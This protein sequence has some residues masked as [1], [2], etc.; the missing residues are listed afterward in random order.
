MKNNIMIVC[1]LVLFGMISACTSV[2]ETVPEPDFNPDALIA[3]GEKNISVW[4]LI[5]E[6]VP[7]ETSDKEESRVTLQYLQEKAL[8][9]PAIAMYNITADSLFYAPYFQI[10]TVIVGGT[11]GVP[12]AQPI[13]FNQK[14]TM[15]LTTIQ[16]GVRIKHMENIVDFEYVFPYT[17]FEYQVKITLKNI[18]MRGTTQ[19]YMISE[20][21]DKDN[22][23]GVRRK[24][25]AEFDIDLTGGNML[26][27]ETNIEISKG[28]VLFEPQTIALFVKSLNVKLEK[29]VGYFPVP[30]LQLDSNNL[31]MN[32]D[33]LSDL[34]N[35]FDMS[36][37]K[38]YLI[39]RNKGFG[40][41]ACVDDL[42]L[43]AK[44]AALTK[45]VSLSSNEEMIFEA[46]LKNTLRIDTFVFTPE[47]SNL[48]D[49]LNLP[50]HGNINYNGTI[51]FNPEG[52]AGTDNIIYADGVSQVD[53]YIEIPLVMKG[54]SLVFQDTLKNLICDQKVLQVAQLTVYSKTDI[55]FG[56]TL[57][58][59]TFYDEGN[60]LLG[61]V[62]FN[63]ALT[64]DKALS[65]AVGPEL[66]EK[67]GKAKYAVSVLCI[68]PSLDVLS[69]RQDA[70]LNINYSLL[71]ETAN[72]TGK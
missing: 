7:E 70:A 71:G 41:P 1:T 43:K 31:K 63:E 20:R 10:D 68:Y 58:K 19:P 22:Q 25:S 49:F 55:P 13:T 16:P 61:E 17:G 9:L 69:I 72:N 62:E 3:L 38:Y 5:G 32:L 28:A 26:K 21:V 51:R 48:I 2:K 12:L 23:K 45:S 46:N 59:I 53:S 40:L 8:T 67:V 24:V 6:S 11:F 15:L 56:M 27:M 35:A 14:D 37:P 52:N 36:D 50:P 4:D 30:P 57:R 65:L 29:A 18:F 42:S 54:T 47:N 33:V 39:I 34:S 64:N 60:N 66:L 44:N